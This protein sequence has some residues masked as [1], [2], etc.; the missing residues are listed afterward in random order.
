MSIQQGIM[1][2][3]L[4]KPYVTV[5]LFFRVMFVQYKKDHKYLRRSTKKTLSVI[6]VS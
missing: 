4:L 6:T 3:L 1:Q 5:T 2:C